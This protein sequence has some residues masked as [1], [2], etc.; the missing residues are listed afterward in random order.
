MFFF[1]HY[2]T[3]SFVHCSLQDDA[4]QMEW[5]VRLLSECI[6]AQREVIDRLHGSVLNALYDLAKSRSLAQLACCHRLQ[7]TLD[8][9]ST[10]LALAER[11]NEALRLEDEQLG[12]G[13]DFDDSAR[14]R[15][16]GKL[17][18]VSVSTNPSHHNIRLTSRS[19]LCDFFY[20]I[21]CLSFLVYSFNQFSV[22]MPCN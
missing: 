12:L 3:C 2:P 15:S 9:Q 18:Q 21:L 10:S 17:Q 5:D 19:L 8:V 22:L 7:R 1:G 11:L 20:L 6:S 4:E 16:I 14:R 13:T